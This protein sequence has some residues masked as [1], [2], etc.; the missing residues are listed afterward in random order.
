MEQHPTTQQPAEAEQQRYK[1]LGVRLDEDIHARLSFIAQLSGSTITDEIRRSI[2][3]R[4][5]AAQ[6]DPELV[7]RAQ[8]VRAEIERE[9]QARQ[10]AISGFFGK[11]A[12]D[13][14][15]SSG[16][17]TSRRTKPTAPLDQA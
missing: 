17:R 6:A 5:D 8:Q 12:V 2:E 14:E 7:E 3:A 15:T 10:Q 11:V 16:T 13:S 4:I 9:A 1:T